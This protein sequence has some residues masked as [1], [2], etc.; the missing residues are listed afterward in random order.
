MSYYC[1]LEF[2][3]YYPP[4]TET[5]TNQEKDMSKGTA[6]AWQIRKMQRQKLLKE[7]QRKIAGTAEEFEIEWDLYR[8]L[9]RLFDTA[10]VGSPIVKDLWDIP[11]EVH[12][13][14][15]L[16]F[17][18]SRLAIQSFE[19]SR[20]EGLALTA[21]LLEWTA[22]QVVAVHHKALRNEEFAHPR[23]IYG[24]ERATDEVPIPD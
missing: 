23:L 21:K 6:P 1:K 7:I 8:L 13:I 14:A 15:L 18:Q 24:T 12:D 2:P 3:W 10:L 20:Q 16:V 4:G 9:I 11:K 5:L 22:G 19:R 17:G